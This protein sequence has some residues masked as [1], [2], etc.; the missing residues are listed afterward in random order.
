MLTLLGVA[1]ATAFMTPAQVG[2]ETEPEGTAAAAPA[3]DGDAEPV[4][5][6]PMRKGVVDGVVAGMRKLR[7][8]H[9]YRLPMSVELELMDRM[10]NLGATTIHAHRGA[11]AARRRRKSCSVSSSTVRRRR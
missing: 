6:V 7:T 4:E 2:A 10:L 8:R 3:A 5:V 1:L 9:G 11:A